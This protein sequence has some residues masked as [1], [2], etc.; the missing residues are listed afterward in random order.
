[1]LRSE[2]LAE[3]SETE[4]K[5][6]I[7]EAMKS[8][9]ISHSDISDGNASLMPISKPTAYCFEVYGCGWFTC[10]SG[11]RVQY[12]NASCSIDLRMVKNCNRVKMPCKKEGYQMTFVEPEFPVNTVK[13]MAQDAVSMFLTTGKGSPASNYCSIFKNLLHIPYCYLYKRVP[14]L[15]NFSEFGKNR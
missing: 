2:L 8:K 6:I 15:A 9:T 5:E 1:M 13:T 11:H 4:I 7:L 10:S 3:P 12:K 14:I